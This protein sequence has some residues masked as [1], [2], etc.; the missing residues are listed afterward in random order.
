MIKPLKLRLRLRIEVCKNVK[1]GNAYNKRTALAFW[2]FQH[3]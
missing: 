1:G 2:D 3:D